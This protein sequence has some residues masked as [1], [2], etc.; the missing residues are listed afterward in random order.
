MQFRDERPL[1]KSWKD[2]IIV[3]RD[4]DKSYSEIVELLS[5]RGHKAT[6][7]LVKRV[8]EKEFILREYR[9]V[10][11]KDMEIFSSIRD[12]VIRSYLD[13]SSATL[14]S[15]QITIKNNF[16]EDVSSFNI[17][18]GIIFQHD[19]YIIDSYIPYP[20]RFLWPSF[21]A[22]VKNADSDAITQDTDTLFVS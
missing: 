18:F 12:T 16:N 1:E 22:F 14:E 2:W 20:L 9:P 17:S 4:D 10:S 19:E 11:I 3:W 6:K 15:V 8:L 13:D 5:Q 21:V 7:S